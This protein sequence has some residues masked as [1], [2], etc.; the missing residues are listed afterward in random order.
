MGCHGLPCG[1]SVRAF[2]KDWTMPFWN[3]PSNLA[4]NPAAE[5]YLMAWN[6]FFVVVVVSIS[7]EMKAPIVVHPIN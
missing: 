2:I 7:K 4:P 3:T 5:R 6:Q 1:T